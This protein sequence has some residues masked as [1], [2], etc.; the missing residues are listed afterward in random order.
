MKT[1]QFDVITLAAKQCITLQPNRYK[2]E[3][4]EISEIIREEPRWSMDRREDSQKAPW[5]YKCTLG[6][7]SPVMKMCVCYKPYRILSRST[8]CKVQ[9]SQRLL[10]R[11]LN[12]DLNGRWSY[13]ATPPRERVLCPRYI[14]TQQNTHNLMHDHH[15]LAALLALNVPTTSQYHFQAKLLLLHAWQL[16]WVHGPLLLPLPTL[17]S[18]YAAGVIFVSI[19]GDSDN[20][21]TACQHTVTVTCHHSLIQTSIIELQTT[22][23]RE[24]IKC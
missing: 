19:P 4:T 20:Q 7:N 14:C 21:L 18:N 13:M 24:E 12:G 17:T 5:V 10:Q 1:L 8:A 3:C 16:Q 2:K 22:P 6:Q 23:D 11:E 9:S 15:L